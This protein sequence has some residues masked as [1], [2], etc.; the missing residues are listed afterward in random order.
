MTEILSGTRQLQDD[1]SIPRHR[2]AIVTD[3]V[4]YPRAYA[5]A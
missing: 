3:A 2:C 5:T 4:V 1:H